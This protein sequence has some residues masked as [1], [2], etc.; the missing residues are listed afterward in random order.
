MAKKKF[1]LKE[2]TLKDKVDQAEKLLD[3]PVVVEEKGQIEKE[4]DRALETNL[5]EIEDDGRNFSN[6]LLVGEAGTGKTARVFA[7]AKK[8]NVN[9]VLVQASSMDDTD[10]G[11]VISK[12][13]HDE[14]KRLATTEMDELDTEPRSVLFL[15][16]YNRA[17]QSVRASLLTL[18]QDHV[19]RDD[20]VKGKR[21]FLK[22]FLFT[23]AAINPDS[24]DYDTD[25]LD[26]AEMSR[27]KRVDVYSDPNNTWQ[28]LHNLYAGKIERTKDKNRKLKYQRK[29]NLVDTLLKSK[30]FK[31]DSAQDK[32]NSKMNGNGLILTARTLTNLLQ[33]CDGTKDDFLANWNN[34]CNSTKKTMAEGILAKYEDIDDKA[35]DA[36]KG[37]SESEIFAKKSSS[38]S[39]RLR[40]R[41]AKM[42]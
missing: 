24:S 16:E 2:E 4:L 21:R 28:Y 20:R 1:V 25:R 19:V 31:F 40:D 22:N 12:G 5:E 38:L 35:N 8:N 13:D 34:F 14:V 30:K 17:P 32:E 42:D 36:L 29:L 10:L 26:D 39:G 6:V 9:I 3:D 23:I 33:N 15:D 18:I 7:W 27:F 41:L 37:G 11:G